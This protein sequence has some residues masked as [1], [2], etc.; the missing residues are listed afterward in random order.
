MRFHTSFVELPEAK[1]YSLTKTLY[2]GELLKWEDGYY[3]NNTLAG[4]PHVHFF[5]NMEFLKQI[6]GKKNI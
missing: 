1:T 5:G 6:I 4:Y 2:N 3:K